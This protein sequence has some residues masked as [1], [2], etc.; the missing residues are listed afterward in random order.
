MQKQ[1]EVGTFNCRVLGFTG[2][3]ELEKQN[4]TCIILKHN[5]SPIAYVHDSVASRSVSFHSMITG[6][7]DYIKYLRTPIGIY[8]AKHLSENEF[9]RAITIIAAA[10]GRFFGIVQPESS[11][12]SQQLTSYS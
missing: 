12:S 1:I 5:G 8:V 11:P 4:D 7:K 10:N 9:L 6:Y 2:G 3:Y